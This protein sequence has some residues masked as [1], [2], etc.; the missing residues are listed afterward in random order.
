MIPRELAPDRKLKEVFSEMIRV[1]YDLH[2]NEQIELA[3]ARYF[4]DAIRYPTALTVKEAEE[5]IERAF[6]LAGLSSGIETDATRDR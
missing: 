5:E 2:K 1:Q 3:L 4:S 6:A